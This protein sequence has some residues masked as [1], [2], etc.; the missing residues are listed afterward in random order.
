MKSRNLWQQEE[1][2]HQDLCRNCTSRTLAAYLCASASCSAN[3]RA[4]SV[5]FCSCS[6]R[7]K[8]YRKWC[9]GIQMHDKLTQNCHNAPAESNCK[10][11]RKRTW[12]MTCSCSCL[13]DKARRSSL[14]S[15]SNCS[16]W[17]I[18][19]Y[20]R[21]QICVSGRT[22]GRRDPLPTKELR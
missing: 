20:E 3:L 1:K 11:K 9:T 13:S 18:S 19:A 21:I 22:P 8:T 10:R 15:C 16:T 17:T 12:S 7:I 4:S 6:T 14:T 2:R 5:N